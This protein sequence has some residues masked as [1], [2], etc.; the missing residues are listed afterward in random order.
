MEGKM[1]RGRGG[2]WRRGGRGG[3]D[4]DGVQGDHRGRGRG[5]SH[6]GRG[7]RDHHRGRG[8]GGSGSAAGFPAPADQDDGFDLE[9]E[10]QEVFS[11]RKLESNWDRYKESERVERE[12]DM[13]TR[14]GEDYHVLLESAGDSFTHFRFS[15]EKDWETDAIPA[16]QMSVVFVD[17]AALARTLQEV[18]LNRR[19]DLEAELLQASTPA[20]LPAAVTPRQEV[21]KA[22][23]FASPS[24]T[25]SNSAPSPAPVAPTVKD[26]PLW[27]AASELAVEDGDEELDQLLGLQKLDNQSA[28]AMEKEDVPVVV[29]EAAV[30]EK[31]AD[32][33][34][35]KS[36]PV[37][38]EMSEEDLEDWLDSMIS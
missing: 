21:P 38:Q 15:E 17:L 34:P 33:S 11:R 23:K 30:E 28:V 12:E 18:P 14:R 7:K 31:S 5:G 27:T 37:R 25:I 22:S 26:T 1:S 2:G 6:R 9:E 13:P 20:D 36:A 8:R 24:K 4:A 29:T 32:A 10:R 35:V 16:A 19:L 3:Q